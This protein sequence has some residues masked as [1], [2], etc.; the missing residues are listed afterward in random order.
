MKE[1]YSGD[2][3]TI[4]ILNSEGRYQYTRM[5]YS[6]Q[7]E[8]RG[9]WHQFFDYQSQGLNP[10]ALTDINLQGQLVIADAVSDCP[11][12]KKPNLQALLN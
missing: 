5:P 9:F 1:I 8:K 6:S 2:Q 12:G 4:I 7:A 3:A 10:E 11:R